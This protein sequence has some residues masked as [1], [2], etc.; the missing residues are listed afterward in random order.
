M[1]DGRRWK[2]QLVSGMGLGHS[3]YK[4]INGTIELHSQWRPEPKSL[5]SE[6]L[7]GV[8]GK[9]HKDIYLRSALAKG[10]T[11]GVGSPDYRLVLGLHHQL[12]L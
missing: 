6:I 12:A 3:L 2:K 11:D 10:L 8:I 5:A 4:D 9:L 1:P 7:I